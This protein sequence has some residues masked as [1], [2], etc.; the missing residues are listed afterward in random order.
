MYSLPPQRACFKGAAEVMFV[1]CLL[2]EEHQRHNW[3]FWHVG[4]IAL[5]PPPHSVLRHGCKKKEEQD[6]VKKISS[7]KGGIQYGVP[8]QEK[9]KVS[10]SETE[11][12]KKNAI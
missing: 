7:K 8:A 3:K 2:W 9:K 11:A 4:Q 5:S 6:M 12:S 10:L 1:L